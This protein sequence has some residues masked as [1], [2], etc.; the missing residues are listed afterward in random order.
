ML[1][2]R[3][4]G[5][6]GKGL[7]WPTMRDTVARSGTTAR[8]LAAG[9]GWRVL[10]FV[11]RSGPAD[12]PFEEQHGCTSVSAVLSGV[13]TYRSSRGRALMAPGSLLLGTAGTCF[14]CGHEHSTGDRCVSFQF[15]P[16][17]AEETAA[18][19]PGVTSLGF[20]GVRVP[21]LERLVPLL[22]ATR[23]LAARPDPFRSEEA[24]LEVLATALSFDRTV[25]EPP[26]RRCDEARVADVVRIIDEQFFEPLSIAGLARAVALPRRRLARVFKRCMGVTPYNYVLNRR[27]EAAAAR[28]RDGGGSVLQVALDVG[29]GDLSE[30]TRRFRARFGC[31]PAA[32]RS[33]HTRQPG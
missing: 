2:A 1:Q 19:L 9:D 29:F 12:R 8:T 11:C 10:D 26:C 17:L 23:D 21:P 30:F 33:R 18:D 15:A 3:L 20:A 22:A 6:W 27:L 31:P 28:L 14:E 13:F 24:A 16:Q 32:Y 25:K 7:D 4:F 5:A